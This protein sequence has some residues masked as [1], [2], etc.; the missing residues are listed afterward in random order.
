MLCAKRHRKNRNSLSTA[1]FFFE[2]TWN[3]Q[4]LENRCYTFI[5]RLITLAVIWLLLYLEL[6]G[7]LILEN[8]AA[9]LYSLSRAVIW[10]LGRYTNNQ[11]RDTRE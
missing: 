6:L 7:P 8:A 2:L 1:T 4:N 3:R 11:A 9:I 5:L 10:T